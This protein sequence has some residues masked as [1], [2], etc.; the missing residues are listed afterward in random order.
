MP[1]SKTIIFKVSVGAKDWV[2]PF[3]LGETITNLL[4]DQE[5][6]LEGVLSISISY[7]E[8]EPTAS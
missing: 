4:M 8:P 6:R 5:E 1:P 2:D 7:E 3:L